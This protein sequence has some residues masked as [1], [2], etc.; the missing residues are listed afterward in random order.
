MALASMAF[1][2]LAERARLSRRLDCDEAPDLSEA[3][4]DVPEF[5][6]SATLGDLVG[7]WCVTGMFSRARRTLMPRRV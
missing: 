7:W 6:V 5:L 3:G 1:I 2:Q 4:S